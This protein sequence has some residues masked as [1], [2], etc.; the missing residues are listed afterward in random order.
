MN[1]KKIFIFAVITGLTFVWF[2]Y[3][4]ITNKSQ[5]PIKADINSNGFYQNRF[6]GFQFEYPENW[7]AIEAN[8]KEKD[9]KENSGQPIPAINTLGGNELYK[10]T[11]Q[12]KDYKLWGIGFVITVLPNPAGRTIKEWR[13]KEIEK[14][15]FEQKIQCAKERIQGSPCGPSAR[16]FIR[17]EESI[18]FKGLDAYKLDIFGI[19]HEEECIQT[20]KNPYVYEL[21]YDSANPDDQ[22]FERHRKTSDDIIS[23]FKFLN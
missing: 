14:S 20:A 17:K 10:V 16:D 23:S 11:I 5:T 9:I 13:E 1:P 2:V 4:F 7:S 22:D 19:D 18:N 15:D 6:Y 12:D 21:C 8:I 3:F